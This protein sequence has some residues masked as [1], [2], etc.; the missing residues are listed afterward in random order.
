MPMARR[1]HAT[2]PIGAATPTG[3]TMSTRHAGCLDRDDAEYLLSAGCARLRHDRRPLARLL[4]AASGRARPYELVGEQ[5]SVAAF[6]AAVRW[7]DAL[8]GSIP[9]RKSDR[10]DLQS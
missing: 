9:L 10:W 7:L 3:A 4:V 8:P 5:A 2:S 1:P 6:E